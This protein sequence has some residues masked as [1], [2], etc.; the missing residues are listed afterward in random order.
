MPSY[1][2]D[3]TITFESDIQKVDSIIID[4]HF[5]YVTLY[6]GIRIQGTIDIS[7]VAHNES[8]D[9]PFTTSIDVDIMCPNEEMCLARGFSLHV[10]DSSYEISD[11]AVIFHVKCVIIGQE[12]VEESLAIE[13]LSDKAYLE[14]NEAPFEL[15]FMERNNYISQ[16]EADELEQLL[17]KEVDMEVISTVEMEP[18]TS[19]IPLIDETNKPQEV[20]IEDKNERKISSEN[21][22]KWFQEEPVVITCRYYVVKKDDTYQSLAQKFK[23]DE[24]ELQILNKNQTLK[25]GMLI[26]IKK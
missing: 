4:D 25:K 17:K 22:Q 8:E 2:L 1:L 20:I 9:Y 14:L 16:K 26:R 12:K 19:D 11:H 3:K 15:A 5:N 7:A 24:G 6:E 23:I 18:L 10:D 13:Q 21:P